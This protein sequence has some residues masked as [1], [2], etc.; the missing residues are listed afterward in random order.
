MLHFQGSSFS[1]FEV[2]ILHGFH[3]ITMRAKQS[4]H[5]TSCRLSNNSP[6]EQRDIMMGVY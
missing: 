4:T 5:L 6:D 3:I 2:K 1:G